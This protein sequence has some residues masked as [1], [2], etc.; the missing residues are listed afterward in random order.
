MDVLMVAR[1]SM[2]WRAGEPPHGRYLWMWT[3]HGPTRITTAARKRGWCRVQAQGSNPVKLA[4]GRPPQA[5]NEQ[6]MCN[7]VGNLYKDMTTAF[8]YATNIDQALQR[9]SSY[10]ASSKFWPNPKRLWKHNCHLSKHDQS[11]QKK[12]FQLSHSACFRPSL[13]LLLVLLDEWPSQWM[14][15]S[16]WLNKT[17]LAHLRSSKF[18]IRQRKGSCLCWRA[19]APLKSPRLR[20]VVWHE[21]TGR[22]SKWSSK[23]NGPLMVSTG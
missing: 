14:E 23:H 2:V 11:R 6:Q 20:L 15:M 19:F 9:I 22:S 8:E 1:W 3:V 7:L 10:S 21:M 5:N 18:S 13:D 4:E 12:R 17:S 16:G